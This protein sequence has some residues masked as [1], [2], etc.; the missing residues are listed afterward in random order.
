M[1]NELTLFTTNSLIIAYTLEL[2][3]IDTDMQGID[4]P[5]DEL[6]LANEK[7]ISKQFEVDG[8]YSFEN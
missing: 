4:Q 7:S 8:I 5:I 2:I 3:Y 6:N 1:F